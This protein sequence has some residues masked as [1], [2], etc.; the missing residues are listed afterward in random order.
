LRKGRAD[1]AERVMQRHLSRVI[2]AMEKL[3]ASHDAY[4]E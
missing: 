1:R 2:G 3:K 4:F